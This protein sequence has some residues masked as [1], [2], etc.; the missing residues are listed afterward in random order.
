MIDPDAGARTVRT[1]VMSFSLS[2]MILYIEALAL[3]WLCRFD[4]RFVAIVER[5]KMACKKLFDVG[6]KRKKRKAFVKTQ[7]YTCKRCKGSVH[8]EHGCLCI[9]HDLCLEFEAGEA[10][11]VKNGRAIV[12]DGKNWEIKR[13]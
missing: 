11:L 6:E 12:C 1:I 3:Y 4:W 5:I 9:K 8:D 13:G 10:V 7:Q 2:L